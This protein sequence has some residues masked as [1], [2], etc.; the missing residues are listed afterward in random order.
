MPESSPSLPSNDS[1][2]T[3]P[4][5]NGS[6]FD[7]I[8]HLRSDG[9]EYWSA[10]ELMPLMGYARW[11]E[12]KN[13]IERAMKSAANQGHY[14]EP[15][16]R[17]SAEKSSGGRP[18]EDSE[19]SRFAAYLVAMNG[20]PNKPEVAAAQAYFAIRTRQAEAAESVTQF[21][22]P[23]TLP[24]ALRAYADEFEA[25]QLTKV[26]NAELEPKAL[27]ADKIL[28][29]EGDLSIRDAAQ[30]LTRAGVKIGAGRLFAELDHRGWIKRALGDG[31][32]RVIQAAIESGYMSVLPQSHYHPKTGVLV[33]DPPQ[34]RVTP[35]GLQRPLADYDKAS[36]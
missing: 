36:A 29:A 18:A 28:T 21:N 11:N 22:I 34:P 25:H 35:K 6:P 14:L 12:F 1:S 7:A 8:R 30:S 16:F 5:A 10:R 3:G 23:K 9:S 13:P 32:Y 19:L 2:L 15:H 33:L 17:R 20:D 24:E 27:V 31:R 26:R 4:H